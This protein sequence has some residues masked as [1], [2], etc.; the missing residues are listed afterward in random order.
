MLKGV[1]DPETAAKVNILSVH[2]T[3]HSEQRFR[4]AGIE[5]DQLPAWL[6]EGA[7]G[8]ELLMKDVVEAAMAENVYQSESPLHDMYYPP[9]N[10]KLAD[11]LTAG[12]SLPIAEVKLMKEPRRRS[13]SRSHKRSSAAN[14]P[15]PNPPVTATANNER[16]PRLHNRHS[17]QQMLII[18][19]LVLVLCLL[20]FIAWHQ[21][22]S[23]GAAVPCAC[24]C[25][26]FDTTV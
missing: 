18:V 21:V 22:S 25:P 23:V 13:R 15:S 2:E 6:F 3:A 10:K 17:T 24:S 1:I 5:K 11:R 12:S 26:M 4:D 8:K 20:M 16:Y 7:C 19:L 9:I 14:S